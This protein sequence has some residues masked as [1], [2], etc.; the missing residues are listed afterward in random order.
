MAD[1]LNSMLKPARK[2]K[3]VKPVYNYDIRQRYIDAHKINFERE[4][5]AAFASGL[6]FL[7]VVPPV[8][9]TNGAQK[10]IC[11]CLKFLGHFAER[12]NSMG[13][14]QRDS[15]GAPIIDRVTGKQKYRKPGSTSGTAD[16]H[17]HINIPSQK[18]PV[19]IKIEYKKGA[20][21]MRKA[22]DRYAA[23]IQASGG[24]Y[25]VCKTVDDFWFYYDEWMKM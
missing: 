3:Q 23:K 20:D 14:P 9:T 17:G 13:I 25:V 22:Q 12:V 4:Y 16:I 18:Y 19:P 5:P 21:S 1:F 7:P 6:Y 8:E 10:Y 11:D 15:N 24:I 2:P